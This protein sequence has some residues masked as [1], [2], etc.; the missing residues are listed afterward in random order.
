MRLQQGMSQ[1]ASEIKCIK[2]CRFMRA[3]NCVIKLHS[4]GTLVADDGVDR[5]SW[6][7][8][9]GCRQK[10]EDMTIKTRKGVHMLLFFLKPLQTIGQQSANKAWWE[11]CEDLP[12]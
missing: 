12:E 10:K 7:T 2:C 8:E 3:R 4:K 9:P 11:G 6:K 5:G 1:C